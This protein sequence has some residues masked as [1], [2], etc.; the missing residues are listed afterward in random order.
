MWFHFRFLFSIFALRFS[1]CVFRFV[2]SFFFGNSATCCGPW[3]AHGLAFVG[4]SVQWL[5]SCTFKEMHWGR[6]S[7]GGKLSLQ[8][9]S[10]LEID[11][12]AKAIG[13]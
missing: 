5:S 10:K 13:N 4:S 12:K 8:I 6:F 9:D 3:P 1:F 7:C 11:S 2:F